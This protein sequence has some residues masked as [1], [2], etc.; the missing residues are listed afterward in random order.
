MMTGGTVGSIT[1]CSARAALEGSAAKCKTKISAMVVLPYNS[2]A[3]ACSLINIP[4]AH[5]GTPPTKVLL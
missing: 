4:S 5:I 1:V 3:K 2:L